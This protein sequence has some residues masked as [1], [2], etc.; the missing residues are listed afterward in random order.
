MLWLCLVFQSH[1]LTECPHSLE[2]L[3]SQPCISLLYKPSPITSD[4]EL[5]ISIGEARLRL[6]VWPRDGAERTSRGTVGLRGQGGWTLN[7]HPQS[8][9]STALEGMSWN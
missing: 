5:H 1:T 4:T 6:Q 3:Q 7:P 8:E 9:G 2:V